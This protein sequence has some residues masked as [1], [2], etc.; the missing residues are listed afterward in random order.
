PTRGSKITRLVG[1][2][3]YTLLRRLLRGENIF[4][5]HRFHLY[6]RL[7]QAGWSHGQVA[8]SYVGLS[9]GIAIGVMQLGAIAAWLSLVG[10]LLLLGISESYLGL[11][12]P[13]T[14]G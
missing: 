13:D 11:P 3:V 2:A 4:Q 5:A 8:G 1:D 14:T 9:A 12:R 10:V 7:H 6:Q